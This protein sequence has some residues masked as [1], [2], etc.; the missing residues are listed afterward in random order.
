MYAD[1]PVDKT[2]RSL[3]QNKQLHVLLAQ[4][5]MLPYKEYLVQNFTRYRETS[6]KNMYFDECKGLI[7]YLKT[8]CELIAP[9]DKSV[10]KMRR[11]IAAI[12]HD[13]GWKSQDGKSVDRE[14][15]N[16]FLL[17][18]GIVKKKFYDL[19]HKELQVAIHQFEK[20]REYQFKNV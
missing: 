15:V 9:A 2:P 10:D 13:M 17:T 12:C 6:S 4:T 5:G 8:D 20:L 16:R 18:Y 7:E 19:D 3:D 14:R 1:L 11:K